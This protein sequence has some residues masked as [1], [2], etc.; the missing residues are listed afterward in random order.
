MRVGD[1]VQI[2]RQFRAYSGRK[3]D[4]Q[5]GDYVYAE[6]LPLVK[7]SRKLAIR[8]SGPLIITE[9]LMKI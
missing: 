7:N 8:W 4:L 6:V 1:E 2:R 5:V 9:S 3:E